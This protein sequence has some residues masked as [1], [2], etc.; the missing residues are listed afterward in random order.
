MRVCPNCEDI[1]NE[2]AGVNHE[3]KPSPKDISIC[4]TC[5]AVNQFDD[6]LDLEPLDDGVLET[7]KESSPA[8]YDLIME[9][10]SRINKIKGDV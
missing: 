4:F 7:M 5:G 2:A 6:K 3:Q 8:N 10:V 9:V 1:V